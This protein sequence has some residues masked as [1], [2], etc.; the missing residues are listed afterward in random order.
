MRKIFLISMLIF[1]A[2]ILILG[3]CAKPAPAPAPTPAPAPAPT[4]AP[5]P[6]PT[7][8][9]TPVSPADFYKGNTLTIIVPTTPGGGSDT[10]ARLVASYLSGILEATVIVDNM[11]G[12]GALVAQ[13]YL[14]RK[15]KPDGLTI[16]TTNPDAFWLPWLYKQEGVEY[17]AD[18]FEIIAQL[19]PMPFVFYTKP[20]GPYT[21]VEALK[22]GKDIVLAAQAPTDFIIMGDVVVAEI[23]GLDAK[24]ISGYP[25]SYECALAVAQGEAD[26][27]TTPIRSARSFADQGFA[28]PLIMITRERDEQMPD[29]PALGELKELTE[30]DNNLLDMYFPGG[31]MYVAPPGTPKD[32]VDFLVDTFNALFSS[33]DFQK[34]IKKVDG[35][36]AGFRTREEL[37]KELAAVV[38]L[39]DDYIN[40]FLSLAEKYTVK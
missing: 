30:Y 35:Y 37:M 3:G 18:E 8:A 11:P 27:H 32:R 6:T 13:N 34:S 38:K 22:Q 7:P 19:Q 10:Y 25:G 23:L 26:G 16:A 12:A 1:L 20:D 5:T 40:V 31:K 33:E 36:W 9:P 4:P 24:V 14:Y 2:A 29:L 39:K 28:H 17:V 15:A 21:S